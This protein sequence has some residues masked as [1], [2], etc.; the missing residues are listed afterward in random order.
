MRRH[1]GVALGLVPTH[2]LECYGIGIVEEILVVFVPSRP[3]V[4][5]TG[6]GGT[7]L[8]LANVFLESFLKPLPHLSGIDFGTK[9]IGAE[10]GR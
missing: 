10:I 9:F 5:S 2:H 4:L 7:T 1:F 3:A 8:H 6:L